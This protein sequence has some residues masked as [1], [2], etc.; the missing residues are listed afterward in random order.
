MTAGAAPFS[1]VDPDAWYAES[2]Q[3]VSEN[4]LMIGLGNDSFDPDGRI[5]RGMLVTILYRMEGTPAVSGR[6]SFKDVK[7]GT[8]Y[9]RAVLWA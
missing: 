2:V 5:S 9:E 8:Y 3:Y 7:K 1:D 4:G 6:M